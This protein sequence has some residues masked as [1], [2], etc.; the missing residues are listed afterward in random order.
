MMDGVIPDVLEFMSSFS[1]EDWNSTPRFFSEDDNEVEIIRELKTDLNK[2]RC[3]LC[4]QGDFLVNKMLHFSGIL[5]NEY[6]FACETCDRSFKCK[7]ALTKHQYQHVDTNF[8]RNQ[9]NQNKR[10]GVRE[11]NQNRRVR[12]NNQNKRVL[13]RENNQNKRVLVRE[14]NQ[15]KRVLVRRENQNKRGHVRENN[16]NKSIHVRKNNQNKLVHV[17]ENNQNKC[18]HVRENVS[19]TEEVS[20]VCQFCDKK[21]KSTK[22][23]QRHYEYKH[24]AITRACEVCKIAFFNFHEFCQHCLNHTRL[25]KKENV[26]EKCGKLF[27]WKTSLKLHLR[28]HS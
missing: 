1:V 25:E 23:L 2:H 19:R 10:L 16:Q 20:A 8:E 13:V 27:M 12:K 14:N 11:N 22:Q 5:N 18:V 28:T 9:S 3:Y 4:C 26:C 7:S 6:K 15:N 21:F 17:R 24:G